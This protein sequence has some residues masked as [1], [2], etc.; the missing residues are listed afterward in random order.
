MQSSSAGRS[1]LTSVS[2]SATTINPANTAN[3]SP[4][5][6]SSHHT[7]SHPHP[8]TQSHQHSPLL[9]SSHQPQ[10]H[11]PSTTSLPPIRQLHPYLPPSGMSYAQH[12]SAEGYSSYPPP[13]SHTHS[14]HQS[15]SQHD[16]GGF[17]S[18]GGGL[19][20]GSIS[21]GGGGGGS[22]GGGGGRHA[23]DDMYANPGAVDSDGEEFDQHGPPKK[24][25]R[26]QALS[27]T[28]CKRRK[29]KCDRF[30]LLFRFIHC[31]F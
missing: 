25:R 30:F 26:R 17:S 23:Q 10:P 9:L 20:G 12:S 11:Q 16:S 15:Y 28:E 31:N 27:C 14:P 1:I 29:I 21:S 18:G 5:R 4:A 2:P 24:K 22:I 7:S 19:G 3:T 13:S 6:G 8:H